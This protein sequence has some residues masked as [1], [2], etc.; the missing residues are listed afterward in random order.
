MQKDL[1]QSKKIVA[2]LEMDYKKIDDYE[3]KL[4]VILE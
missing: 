2:G 1:Y 3:K 4:H